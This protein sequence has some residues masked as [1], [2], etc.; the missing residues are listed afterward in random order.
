ME[1]NVKK[2]D[3]VPA[4]CTQCGA[5]LEVDPTQEAAVCKFC[6]TPFIVSKAI[7][8]YT[9]EHADHVTVDLKGSVDSFLDFADKQMEKSREER[10]EKRLLE[11][12]KDKMIIKSMWKFIL[13]ALVVA[14]AFWLIATALHLW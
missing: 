1:E 12:E 4:V 2:I 7:N 13:I 10:K 8:N 3:L 9:I 5:T 6:N 14:M 11:N